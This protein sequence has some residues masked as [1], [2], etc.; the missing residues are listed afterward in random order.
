ML[1]SDFSLNSI[2]QMQIDSMGHDAMRMWEN[3]RCGE[4]VGISVTISEDGRNK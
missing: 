4:I 1:H 3:S 2:G